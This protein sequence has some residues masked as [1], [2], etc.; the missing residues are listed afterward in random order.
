[1]TLQQALALGIAHHQA[2]RLAQAEA[3]Y[4]EILAQFPNN[5]DALH[6]LGLLAGQAGR[7][8]VAEDLIRKAIAQSPQ[9]VYLYNLGRLFQQAGR[10]TEAADLHRQA[11]QIDPDFA[12]AWADLGTVLAAQG[13][14][15]DAVSA[16]QN[17]ARLRPQNPAIRNALG[18]NLRALGRI[19]DAEQCFLQALQLQ[20][21]SAESHGNLGVLY[22]S[23]GRFQQA[24]DHAQQALAFAPNH[25]TLHFNK[26]VAL[27]GLGRVVEAIPCYQKAVELKPD[28]FQ[29]YNNLANALKLKDHFDEAI[30]AYRRALAIQ[31][32]FVI[33][34]GNLAATLQRIGSHDESLALYRRALALCPND[35]QLHS[36][37]IY[38]LLFAPRSSAEIIRQELALWNDRFAK[39]LHRFIQPH[40]NDRNPDRRLRIG[41][42][43]P[44]FHDNVVARNMLPIFQHR[45][46][47]AVEFFCYSNL[48]HHDFMTESFRRLTDHW[49]DIQGLTDEQLAAQIRADRIDILV[50]LALHM[51]SNSLLTFA[52]K[53]A[54]IQATFA[55]YPGSTGLDTID[56]RLSDPFLDPPENDHLYVEKTFRLPHS[57]WC[58]DPLGE[59]AVPNPLPAAATSPPGIVTF[60]NLNY[61]GKTN[62]PTFDLW[63]KVLRAV[64]RSRLFL[65]C[66][67]GAHRRQT[68]NFFQ[69][70]GIAPGRIAFS[71]F[72]HRPEYLKLYRQIDIV[73]DTLP[74][75]GH[76]T[77]LDTLWMG[78]PIVTLVGQTV[79][80]RASYSQLMNLNLSEL[81]TY[82]P[83][84]FIATAVALAHDLPRLQ[85]LRATL[86]PRMEKSPLMDA[87]AFTRDLESAFR[88][89]WQ[90]WCSSAT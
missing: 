18:N 19:A 17:A 87:P 39:P 86:R 77:G 69:S 70:R 78:V 20:P 8:D 73:L 32:D 58:Y 33:T 13:K 65:L 30:A 43:S 88:Q 62:E 28:Y 85:N 34:L 50:D 26:G 38:A 81:I 44:D 71:A 5:S 60:G 79:V 61:L 42:V 15:S 72:R 12:D 51:G 59:T 1:M 6:L 46:R 66:P 47:Q 55:G 64:D 16:Y 7:L 11:L 63:S 83:E 56:Y 23:Q 31:P 48:V 40:V 45:D 2:G 22:E 74:Y 14:T 68:L 4:R 76:T 25:P 53:P 57:F 37:Y 75:N 21:H 49:A 80:G 52:R 82:T 41:F 9:P 27:A 3:V 36:G 89:M 35:P 24:L 90:T 10:L 54:P 84:A 29:A 67:E